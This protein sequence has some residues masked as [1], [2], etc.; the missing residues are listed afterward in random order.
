MGDWLRML[1]TRTFVFFKGS[2]IIMIREFILREGMILVMNSRPCRI[3][4]PFVFCKKQANS[5]HPIENFLPSP[6]EL[7]LF[8]NA[9][10]AL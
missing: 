2:S 1:R 6:L 10:E 8:F 5:W 7:L 3:Q 9:T 4:N